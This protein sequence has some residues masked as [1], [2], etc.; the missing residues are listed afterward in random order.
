[1]TSTA[2]IICTVLFVKVIPKDLNKREM[3]IYGEATFPL[4]SN[5]EWLESMTVI[6]QDENCGGTVA[7]INGVS[8]SDLPVVISKMGFSS[9][10][11][12][13]HDNALPG[14]EINITFSKN[15]SSN[16]VLPYIWITETREADLNL[17]QMTQESSLRVF[18][19]KHCDDNIIEGAKCYKTKSRGNVPIH[20]TVTTAGYIDT[21]QTKPDYDTDNVGIEWSYKFLAYNFTDIMCRYK[22]TIQ[23]VNSRNK[24]FHIQISHAFNFVDTCTLINLQNYA[25]DTGNEDCSIK[26]S[27]LKRRWDITV[28]I[29]I[30]YFLCVTLTVTFVITSVVLCLKRDK[31]R[32]SAIL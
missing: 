6:L 22:P 24:A 10:Q 1:M 11:H 14:S 2:W 21:L 18:S 8:C 30:V 9:D 13:P 27:D 23:H 17:D 32:N 20:Y 26:I 3:M 31:H 4:A 12:S 15:F 25:I 28:L 16:K 29:L 19:S 7:V 5:T